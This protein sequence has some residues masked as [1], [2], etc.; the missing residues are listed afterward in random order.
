M[1]KQGW[2]SINP[3]SGQLALSSDKR[4]R[5]RSDEK[6]GYCIVDGRQQTI[7]LMIDRVRERRDR[8]TKEQNEWVKSKQLL[9]DGP[10]GQDPWGIIDFSFRHA[11]GNLKAPI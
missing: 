4:E 11:C 2:P 6:L 1:A 10:G 3:E 5:E 7:Y 8:Q 9:F